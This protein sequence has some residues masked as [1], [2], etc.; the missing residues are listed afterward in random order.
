MTWAE[1]RIRSFA[2]KRKREW[3]MMM[4]REVSYEVFRLQFLFGKK[5]PPKKEKYWPISDGDRKGKGVTEDMIRA[6]QKEWDE[7][8]KNVKKNG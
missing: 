7:Y 2:F 6:F 1:F 3:E 5:Q 8:E 4:I